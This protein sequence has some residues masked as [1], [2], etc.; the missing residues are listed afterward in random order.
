MNFSPTNNENQ[1][2][3]RNDTWLAPYHV[4]SMDGNTMVMKKKKNLSRWWC[5]IL[6][7]TSPC[8]PQWQ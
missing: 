7:C 6:H 1:L 4:A 2:K 8:F 5:R 3:M